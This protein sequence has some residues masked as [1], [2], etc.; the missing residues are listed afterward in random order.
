MTLQTRRSPKGG[1]GG[2][3]LPERR[4]AGVVVRGQ[5]AQNMGRLRRQGESLKLPLCNT[6]VQCSVSQVR[7]E[8]VHLEGKHCSVF[9]ETTYIQ[10]GLQFYDS[11]V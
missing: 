11:S 1:I 6:L 5:D 4:V 3:V 9:S 10:L 7:Q 8:M 2:E